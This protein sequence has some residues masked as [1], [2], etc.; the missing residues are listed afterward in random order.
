MRFR[1]RKHDRPDIPVFIP[2]FYY[3]NITYALLFPLELVSFKLF[4]HNLLGCRL[5]TIQ[6]TMARL[7]LIFQHLAFALFCL[8]SSAALDLSLE[9]LSGDLRALENNDQRA[10]KR[11]LDSTHQLS[12]RQLDTNEQA[13]FQ[14]SCMYYEDDQCL[15]GL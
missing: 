10:L 9:Q 5:F 15:S 4:T 14:Y 8:V 3:H 2:R 1:L 12:R 13:W 7:I 11:P 6:R